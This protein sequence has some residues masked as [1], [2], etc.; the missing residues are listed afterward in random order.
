MDRWHPQRVYSGAVRGEVVI[1][2]D[3]SAQGDINIVIGSARTAYRDLVESP[4]TFGSMQ[5]NVQEAI[6]TLLAVSEMTSQY[7]NEGRFDGE[8]EQELVQLL[9]ECRN[10]LAELQSMGQ[11]FETMDTQAFRQDD[12]HRLTKSL[13]AKVKGL[14]D[15]NSR[16]NSSML[17]LEKALKRYIAQVK[18]G[19]RASTILS[20]VS[21]SST[22]STIGQKEWRL[23]QEELESVGIT[24]AQFTANREKVL[25]TLSDAFQEDVA[26][27]SSIEI[28]KA[29][30][31]GRLLSSLLSRGKDLLA[32][33][34]E[35][36][37][38]KAKDL[39]RKGAD[40]DT[41]DSRGFTPLLVAVREQN[42]ELANLLLSYKA[43]VNG[44]VRS[45]LTSTPF[46]PLAL[47][48]DR[49]SVAIINL[50]LDHGADINQPY[51]RQMT[52]LHYAVLYK[53]IDVIN[54]LLDRGA[55]ISAE[56]SLNPPTAL[57]MAIDQGSFD[58][59]ETLVKHRCDI[60][61]AFQDGTP[62][63][64]AI[65]KGEP[66]TIHY[67]LQNN[68]HVDT[69]ALLTAVE[70]QNIE[71]L[72][73]LLMHRDQACG[74]KADLSTSALAASRM[75]DEDALCLLLDKGADINARTEAEDHLTGV[76]KG[77]TS[78]GETLVWFA[79][80]GGQYRSLNLLLA[81]GA[82]IEKRAYPRACIRHTSED[83]LFAK[84]IV[85]DCTAV[86][87]AVSHGHWDCAR[88]LVRHGGDL[89]A[90]VNRDI[91]RLVHFVIEASVN[92][93]GKLQTL[94]DMGADLNIEGPC[95]Q[96]PLHIVCNVAQNQDDRVSMADILV[97]RGAR[98]N[99][100]DAWGETPLHYAV[101]SVSPAEYEV[102][103]LEL[104]EYLLKKG[105]DPKIKNSNGRTPFGYA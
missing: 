29:G 95:G 48:V 2:G 54:T 32:A 4:Q 91:R 69:V 58:I 94:A 15:I 86:Q 27:D 55:E 76:H 88:L 20:S 65:S 57:G 53:D 100:Q 25:K 66:H 92:P 35:E 38:T 75:G 1:Q 78:G 61:Q 103:L 45:T 12:L 11:E 22:A 36:N 80:S 39:L 41:Q 72:Q 101:N 3:L 73:F 33:V 8:V 62:L 14:E 16:V 10:H 47:A 23:I 70:M 105:A 104:V 31:L 63:S 17:Q 89:N 81:K 87:I 9:H 84:T 59:V 74:P 51:S 71:H 64:L 82:D 102:I 42:F 34:K 19:E 43:D 68:A 37:I 6:K 24:A 21:S 85:K 49:R 26:G 5:K 67:L 40:V 28:K 77:F 18:D 93:V 13:D 60:N 98:V 46:T 7:L 79:A 30:Q 96:T 99:C 97:A 83:C 52:P 56:S 50:L 44:R 90:W